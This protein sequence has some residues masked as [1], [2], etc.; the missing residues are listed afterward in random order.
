MCI[1]R[2]FISQ[3]FTQAES[4]TVISPYT[5]MDKLTVRKIS[6]TLCSAH[7][8]RTVK[9]FSFTFRTSYSLLKKILIA[10]IRSTVRNSFSEFSLIYEQSCLF[11]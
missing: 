7:T 3:M 6:F 8:Y 1:V 11:L 10:Q 4:L 2:M 5:W 9:Q